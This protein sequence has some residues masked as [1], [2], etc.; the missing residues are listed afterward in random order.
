MNSGANEFRE[1][2][3]SSS[4]GQGAGRFRECLFTDVHRLPCSQS[5]KNILHEPGRA[6]AGPPR[7][8]RHRTVL[9]SPIMRAAFAAMPH[10]V[11][12]SL[13]TF[14]PFESASP[15]PPDVSST[16]PSVRSLR[17]PLSPPEAPETVPGSPE[18]APCGPSCE[19][20]KLP[21]SGPLRSLGVALPGRTG[22]GHSHSLN[23]DLTLPD[24]AAGSFPSSLHMDPW[25]V[26]N[27]PSSARCL[28][29]LPEPRR[30]SRESSLVVDGGGGTDG[31]SEAVRTWRKA[32]SWSSMVL[33]WASRPSGV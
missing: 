14:N 4:A 28:D 27:A 25:R 17:P 8:R 21:V 19:K 7:L 30:P 9:C 15:Q 23:D 10:A 32:F 16:G 13:L 26:P 11:E 12:R 29:A 33:R 22:Q 6:P 20:A 31:T 5:E 2:V 1:D 24:Q 18:V 3:S